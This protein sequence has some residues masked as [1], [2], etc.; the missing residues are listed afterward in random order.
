MSQLLLLLSVLLLPQVAESDRL[1][2]HRVAIAPSESSTAVRETITVVV[3]EEGVSYSAAPVLIHVERDPAGR[4]RL[5][6]RDFIVYIDDRSVTAVDVRNQET[7]LAIPHEGRPTQLLRELFA[8]LP[9]LW[10]Q[11]A[12]GTADDLALVGS[13]HPSL[14]GLGTVAGQSDA[15]GSELVFESPDARVSIDGILPGR[16]VLEVDSGD[17]VEEGGRVRWEVLSDRTAPKGT[18][19]T[20]GDRIKVDH[21]AMLAPVAAQ[22]PPEIGTPAPGF[23]APVLDGGAFDLEEALGEVVVLDFWASWC[24]PCRMALPR[25]QE[26]SDR[27]GTLGLPVRVLTVN[28]QEGALDPAA[29]RRTVEA[30]RT[31]LALELPVLLDPDGSLARRWGVSALPTT[32][33]VDQE[34]RIAFVHQGA[35]PEFIQRLEA[36]LRQLLPT[37]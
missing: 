31:S 24:Q 6:V 25:L 15:E 30:A 28:T 35:G 37:D 18:T 21:L 32:V 27:L 33:V 5:E 3:E 16:L 19:F 4:V 2:S 12:L 9:S 10:L 34:G 17:W 22:G 26:L 23:E 7:Y 20:P 13:L 8:D 11:L 1:A 29:L 36:E 14:A